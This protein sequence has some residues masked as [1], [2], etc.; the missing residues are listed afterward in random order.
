[1]PT[2]RLPCGASYDDLV[3]QV[4][5][6]APA[7]DPGHQGTCPH[8]RATLAELR[9]L[10]A[11]VDDLAAEDVRAPDALLAAVMAQV[12][13]LAG[14][15]WYATIDTGRGR[16]RIAARIVGAVA[17]LAAQEVPAVTLAL[18]AG[19]TPRT[20]SARDVAGP[21][22][23]PASDVGVAG[24]HVVVDVQIAVQLGAPLGEVAD[25]VRHRI[26][27]RIAGDL[28]LTP[29]EVNVTVV[30]VLTP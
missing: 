17:R 13:H 20:A 7:A 21:A 12:R 14:D 27:E 10:W 19:R 25:Q 30:D 23:E 29:V 24:P 16:T 11:P 5:E 4:T 6:R 9:R 15:S 26:A 8:C 2:S 3:V 1:M 22:G 18:G 28:G